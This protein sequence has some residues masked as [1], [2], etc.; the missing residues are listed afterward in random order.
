M[1]PSQSRHGRFRP[2]SRKPWATRG[3]DPE[4]SS[5]SISSLFVTSDITDD[6]GNVL[7]DARQG[8]ELVRRPFDLDGRD[9]RTLQGGEQ[10]APQRVAEMWLATPPKGVANGEPTYENTETVGRG[11]GWWQGFA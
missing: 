7:A 5:G 2:W 11:A 6:V 4:H 10:H 8:R 9:C 3:G 1:A